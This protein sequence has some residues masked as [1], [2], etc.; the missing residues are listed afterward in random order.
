M[1]GIPNPGGG[2]TAAAPPPPMKRGPPEPMR[3]SSRFLV[4]SL[5]D[6]KFAIQL[7][8]FQMPTDHYG[9]LLQLLP[10]LLPQKLRDLGD[11]LPVP[12]ELL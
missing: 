4:A 3:P 7:R 1:Y 9:V 6:K 5:V 8:A 10:Q 12:K 11:L 2:C